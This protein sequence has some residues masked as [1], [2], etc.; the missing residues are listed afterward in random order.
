[1]RNLLPSTIL[2]SDWRDQ[3][4]STHIGVY[5]ERLGLT[6]KGRRWGPCPACG[7]ERE[8]SLPRPPLGVLSGGKGFYANC[9]RVSMDSIDL[10][11][12]KL[13]GVPGKEAGSGFRQ[14][15]AWFEGAP[16]DLQPGRPVEPEALR[17][18]PADEVRRLLQNCMPVARSQDDTVRRFLV[19]IR[20][21]SARHTPAGLVPPPQWDGWRGIG[22][23][24][25]YSFRRN[26]PLVVG[27]WSAAGALRSVHG[28]AVRPADRKTTWP[29]G[30]SS[31]GLLF[32]DPW[33]GRRFL[34]GRAKAQQVVICEGITDYLW[35]CQERWRMKDDEAATRAILGITSGSEDALRAVPWSR[36]S[37]ILVLTDPD[38]QG[39]KYLEKIAD[40]VSPHPVLRSPV[41]HLRN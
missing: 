5:A 35:A 27:A 36:G 24:W 22:N 32:A 16:A 2:V 21:Y 14:V 12:W 28:R 4:R 1:M 11:S 7:T 31:K 8:N 3:V 29:A 18:P 15:R 41:A 10:V 26:F 39:L 38:R 30:F 25:P 40:A 37:V 6:T 33:L 9:C 23:W 13:L 19:D 20:G 34:R 17:Y